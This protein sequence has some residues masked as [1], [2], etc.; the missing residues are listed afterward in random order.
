[1]PSALPT[2]HFRQTYGNQARRADIIIATTKLKTK[3]QRGWHFTYLQINF[4]RCC[5]Y[6]IAFMTGPVDHVDGIGSGFC[7]IAI[8]GK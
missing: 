4:Q 1:M 8:I 2:V 5:I 7:S 6:R 3:P